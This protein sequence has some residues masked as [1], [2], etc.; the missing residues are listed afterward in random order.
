MLR[1]LPASLIRTT[2]LAALAAMLLGSTGCF[3]ESTTGPSASADEA[4]A[5]PAPERLSFD[6]GFFQEPSSLDRASHQNFFNAYVRAA[7]A[8]AITHLVLTP[9][10]AAFTVALHTLPSP[11]EDGSYLWIYT[12]VRGSDESQIRLRGTP[13]GDGRAAW[14]MRVSST[15]EGLDND[16]WFAGETWNDGDGGSWQF[17]D[18][19][20]DDAPHVARLEWDTDAHGDYLRFTDDATNPGDALEY[21]EDGALHSFTFDDYDAEALS[22]FVK[23]DAV[24]GN[25]SLR[26]PDYNGGQVACWDE[27]QID[28]V[29]DAR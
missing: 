22:W 19:A 27:N 5:L 21:R 3:E 20:Q 1:H 12:W 25:G 10:V 2:T 23:W 16:L 18:P 29:C 8:G 7:V 28:T 13:L 17:H 14:E 9:P 15:I 24:L 6:F 4:P 11:Q 26:A